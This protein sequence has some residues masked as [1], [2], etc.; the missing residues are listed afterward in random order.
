MSRDDNAQSWNHNMEVRESSA[1]AQLA[2]QKLMANTKKKAVPV[3]GLDGHHGID[4]S[5]GKDGRRGI[6]AN[7]VTL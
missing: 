5:H 6:F 7:F 1:I 3:I 2:Q 4:T